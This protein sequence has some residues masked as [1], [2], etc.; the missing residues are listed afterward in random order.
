MTIFSKL[1]LEVASDPLTQ[2]EFFEVAIL[3]WY[4]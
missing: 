3:V 2:D 1:R 4:V